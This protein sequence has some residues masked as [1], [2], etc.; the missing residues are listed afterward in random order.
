MATTSYGHEGFAHYHVL[1]TESA[2]DMPT[3]D[4]GYYRLADARHYVD[5]TLKRILH[6]ALK[7]Q[8]DDTFVAIEQ[9]IGNIRKDWR[10][11][12]IGISAWR[13]LIKGHIIP[14]DARYG[15]ANLDNTYYEIKR[16]R[17]IGCKPELLGAMTKNQARYVE[18]YDKAMGF[19]PM[20]CTDMLEVID[21][22]EPIEVEVSAEDIELALGLISDPSEATTEVVM[23]GNDM[24]LG[25]Y[26]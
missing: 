17:S 9:V 8:P 11:Q 7:V 24:S 2:R 25:H 10:V 14:R 12:V 15:P 26:Y 6:R 16:C 22:G 3:V 23:H 20:D 4:M 21:L 13:D 1:Q 5:D 19:D 18:W